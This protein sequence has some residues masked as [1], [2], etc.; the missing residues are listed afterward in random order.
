MSLDENVPSHFEHDEKSIVD[1][2]ES[3]LNQIELRWING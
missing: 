3:C 1:K 2:H